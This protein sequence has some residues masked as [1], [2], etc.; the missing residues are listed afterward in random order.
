MREPT[1]SVIV[2]T[3]Q[4]P[5]AIARAA[6][7]LRRLKAPKGGY[8]V[9]VVDDGTDAD[10]SFIEKRWKLRLIRQANAGPA[11]ARNAGVA[12]A[13]GSKVA[14]LDD[15]CVPAR[16]WLLRLDEG[17]EAHP[18]AI[19][20]GHTEN[21]LR[22]NVYSE[23]SQQIVGF[24]SEE[25]DPAVEYFAETQFLASNNI[26]MSRATFEAIGGFDTSFPLAAGEDRALCDAQTRR[27]EKCVR[28]PSARVFHHHHLDLTSF[29]K[30]HV[31]YGRGA[32]LVRQ[33]RAE[34]K[35]GNAKLERAQFYYDLVSRPVKQGCPRA[36]QVAALLGLA[37]VATAWGYVRE[38]SR[39]VNLNVPKTL[40][41]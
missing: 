4:R 23:A 17:L 15:D 26:A 14:F 37:Q 10:L 11:K 27:G 20:G 24:L 1:W 3:Y 38:A 6:K 31:H 21:A 32:F 29:W 35:H 41:P 18:N 13:R 22:Q 8:E 39:S 28:V 2:P 25:E 33:V 9:I 36:T 5:R 12:A 34:T 40:T 7:A 16:D 30:Q 19:V